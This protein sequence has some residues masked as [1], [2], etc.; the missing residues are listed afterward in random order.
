MPS[1]NKTYQNIQITNKNTS[2]K[3]K[4]IDATVVAN[5]GDPGLD[6]DYHF[7]LLSRYV[8]CKIESSNRVLT[9]NKYRNILVVVKRPEN[10]WISYQ[11]GFTNN[12]TTQ[13]RIDP[14]L[15]ANTGPAGSFSVNQIPR[16][17]MPYQL[18]ETI[19]I[20]LINDK[21]FDYSKNQDTFFQSVCTK[22]SRSST[23]GYYNS[24]HTQGLSSNTYISS[25][26]GASN[27]RIKT[28]Y[29]T[30]LTNSAYTITCNK[31]QYEAFI[32][33]KYGS[34]QDYLVPL[35]QNRADF[36]YYYYGNGGYAYA[37]RYYLNL[38]KVK[39][40]DVNVAQRARVPNNNCVPLVVTTPNSFTVP[41]SRNVGVINY[42]PTYITKA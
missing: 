13:S 1:T 41:K 29:P 24:W 14:N 35:F 15:N 22:F 21:D 23:L 6:E 42:T 11:G 34:D 38:N 16:I 26:G 30:D 28:I 37:N 25:N 20:K 9:S 32:L 31:L 39:Y 12:P 33:S 18:G 4:L 27:L 10:L 19:K 36:P 3:E 8:I 5:Y 7:D 40:V 2:G 17:N